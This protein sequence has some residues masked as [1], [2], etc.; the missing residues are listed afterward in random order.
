MHMRDFLR[1]EWLPLAELFRT[2]YR[3]E[4]AEMGRCFDSDVEVFGMLKDKSLEGATLRHA[5]VSNIVLQ[6]QG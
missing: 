6:K 5:L 2:K 3:S 4:I 1:Y